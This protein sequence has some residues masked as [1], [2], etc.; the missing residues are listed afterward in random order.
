MLPIIK[1]ELVV[2]SR[3]LIHPKEVYI[4]SFGKVL[5]IEI[6]IDEEQKETLLE[7]VRTKTVEYANNALM[8]TNVKS[9]ETLLKYFEPTDTI[10]DCIVDFGRLLRNKLPLLNIMKATGERKK[11]QVGGDAI[12]LAKVF[13]KAAEAGNIREMGRIKGELSVLTHPRRMTA[14]R[15]WGIE[16][17]EVKGPFYV[18][19]VLEKYLDLTTLYCERIVKRQ[20][21]AFTG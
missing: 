14:L 9:I 20:S 1:A 13:D 21:A 11:R 6:G 15:Y 4:D 5:G 7:Y 8:L 16:Y 3:L 18:T 17:D 12:R 19:T 10:T 2:Q